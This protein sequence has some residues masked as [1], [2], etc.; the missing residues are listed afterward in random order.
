MLNVQ[1]RDLRDLNNKFQAGG[2]IK[3]L[4]E[5]ITRTKEE[6]VGEFSDEKRLAKGLP[7]KA[8]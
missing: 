1:I 3:A 6:T 5:A 8:P 4:L 2:D 7:S